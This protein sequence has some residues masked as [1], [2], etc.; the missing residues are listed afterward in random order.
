M[1]SLSVCLSDTN[2]HSYTLL[3][4]SEVPTD[5][6]PQSSSLCWCWEN[7]KGSLTS[8]RGYGEG[9]NLWLEAITHRHCLKNDKNRNQTQL[10]SPICHLLKSRIV[11]LDNYG[12][13]E[14]EVQR[15]L[16]G[17]R[18]P[19]LHCCKSLIN[20]V[21]T[22]RDSLVFKRTLLLRWWQQLIKLYL[23]PS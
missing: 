4:S 7:F 6:S 1:L 15:M 20:S 12:K 14:G 16:S 23:I 9:A 19:Y 22:F 8:Q 10:H 2:A 17:L 21:S 11:D 5:L 3:I 18:L 13:D